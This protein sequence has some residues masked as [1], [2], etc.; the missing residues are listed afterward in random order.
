MTDRIRCFWIERTDRAIYVLRRYAHAQ[1]GNEC[2]G[3]MRFHDARAEID[4]HDLILSPPDEEGDQYIEAIPAPSE[5]DPRWPLRC[6]ACMYDF[7]ERDAFQVNQE[8]IYERRDT[9]ERYTLRDAPAGAMWDSWWMGSWQGADG[10]H[11]TVKLPDGTD[12]CVDGPAASDHKPWSREGTIPD[13]TANP[14]IL[15][16]NYHGFLRAGY[17]ERC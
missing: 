7:T 14:S 5:D 9:G 15:S 4:E 12:W 17:L 3:E 10:I 1:P 13:V 16:P 11:L 6:S 2:P 8:P